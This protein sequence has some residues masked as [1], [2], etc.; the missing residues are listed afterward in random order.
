MLQEALDYIVK[1]GLFP[2][3]WTF[4]AQ[5]ISTTVLFLFLKSKVWKPMQR[6]L[7]KRSEIIVDELNSAKTLNEEAYQNKIKSEEELNQ[8]RLEAARIIEEAKQQAEQTK[9]LI[10][11]EAEEEARLIKEKA[12]KEIARNQELAYAKLKENAVELAFVAA[13][14]LI[15]ANLDSINNK[16]MIE[17]FI[18]GIGD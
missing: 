2:N 14:K 1:S 17:D 18:Q 6:F 16:K 12:N 3:P 5:I 4:I 7:E 10:I 15:H 13:E 9:A 8:I 11:K